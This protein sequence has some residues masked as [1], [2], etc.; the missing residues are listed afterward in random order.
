MSAAE[1]G[2]AEDPVKLTVTGIS[3]SFGGVQAVKDISLTVLEGMI[4][5]EVFLRTSWRNRVEF[6]TP[7]APIPN[8]APERAGRSRRWTARP[9]AITRAATRFES[10]AAP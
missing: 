1:Q 4:F 6:S 10:T 7:A 2:V 8:V 9:R 3:K 5:A